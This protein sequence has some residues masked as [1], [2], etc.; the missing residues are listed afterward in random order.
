[1]RRRKQNPGQ[2]AES[3]GKLEQEMK[4][5]LGKVMWNQVK[6]WG[7]KEQRHMMRR[8]L[9]NTVKENRVEP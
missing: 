1:M 5:K 2:K 8:V 4:T 6:F 3:K 7:K 9:I